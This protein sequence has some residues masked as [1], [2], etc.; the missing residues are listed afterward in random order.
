MVMCP[1]EKEGQVLSV[2]LSWLGMCFC[3]LMLSIVW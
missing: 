1:A 3:A 2:A